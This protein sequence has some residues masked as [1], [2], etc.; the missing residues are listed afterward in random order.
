MS[1]WRP[2]QMLDQRAKAGDPF[3]GERS[4]QTFFD[5]ET[6][7]TGPGLLTN[8]WLRLRS[9]LSLRVR[10]NLACCPW[11]AAMQR[12]RLRDC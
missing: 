6:P 2:G 7:D 1:I 11:A 9:V 4:E 8:P 5:I 10:G 3:P 12:E